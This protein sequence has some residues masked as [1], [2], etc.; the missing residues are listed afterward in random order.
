MP[1]LDEAKLPNFRWGGGKYQ[2]E[3]TINP[4]Q[5]ATTHP[6]AKPTRNEQASAVGRL[7]YAVVAS[8][9]CMEQGV[10]RRPAS[11]METIGTAR[12]RKTRSKQ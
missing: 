4:M 9:E 5:S 11:V 12:A 1:I 7:R 10:A 3:M 6:A 8:V 2:I